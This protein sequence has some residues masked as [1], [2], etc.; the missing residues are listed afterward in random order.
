MGHN[1]EVIMNISQ[2][3]GFIG[4]AVGITSISL[5]VFY[6]SRQKKSERIMGT[7]I[8]TISKQSQ[9]V[10]NSLKDM[11]DDK[12]PILDHII[13]QAESASKNMSALNSTLKSFY[14]DYYKK[15]LDSKEPKE[16]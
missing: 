7:F 4:I 11:I 9:S 14:E 16:K 2:F 5:A 6:G 12:K 8:R 3:A 10:A 1:G 13:G 15:K